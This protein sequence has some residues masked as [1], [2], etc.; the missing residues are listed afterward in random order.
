MV[1]G[2]FVVTESIG[3]EASVV[4]KSVEPVQLTAA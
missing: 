2:L 4:G 3:V 1:G